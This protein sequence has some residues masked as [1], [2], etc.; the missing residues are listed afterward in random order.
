L[1]SDKTLAISTLT[2]DTLYY[3]FAIQTDGVISSIEA[4]SAST[5][6]HG[7]DTSVSN[8][9]VEVRKTIAGGALDSTK[10]LVGMAYRPTSGTNLVRSWFNDPGYRAQAPLTANSDNITSTSFIEIT[11]GSSTVTSLR[12]PFLIW[13]NETVTSTVLAATQRGTV[14]GT[15]YISIGYDGTTAED[16]GGQTEESTGTVP[17]SLTAICYKTGL[18]EGRHD[19]R[20]LVAVSTNNM[21]FIGSATAGKR[22]THQIYIPP[23]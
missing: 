16:T 5:Y 6:T 3:I 17:K 21:A 4:H 23:R 12:L 15:A 20:P 8:Y 22:T 1:L 9:G 2:V 13:T 18:S 19:S 7:P 10:T 11:I 14:A